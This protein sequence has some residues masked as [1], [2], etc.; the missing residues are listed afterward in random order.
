ERVTRDPL[1]GRAFQESY[2]PPLTVHQEVALREIRLALSGIAGPP[3]SNSPPQGRRGLDTSFLV[4][5]VTG[6]GKTELYM[7]ALAA[8]VAGGKKGIVLVPESALEPPTV[9][10]FSARFPGRVAVL[11]S[12]VSAGEEYDE[13]WRVRSGEF[14]VVI[15]SRGAVFSPQ[16]DL[17]LIV[18]DEEH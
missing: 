17:G 9:A 4:Q 8:C 13:W 15:G 11:H 7:Q 2:A 1:S 3:L 12:G 5:E 14:D 16:P 18:I 10:S 6:S